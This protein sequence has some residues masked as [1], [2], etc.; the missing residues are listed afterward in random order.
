MP[1]FMNFS[2]D[3]CT[4]WRTLRL[5]SSTRGT[6]IASPHVISRVYWP[7]TQ[8]NLF[9]LATKKIQWSDY[10]KYDS[11]DYRR[12]LSSYSLVAAVGLA[13]CS[14]SD[15]GTVSDN[16]NIINI[17]ECTCTSLCIVFY[18]LKCYFYFLFS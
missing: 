9:L 1:F 15:R 13:F 2:R 6:I 12:Y 8:R 17:S 5:I 14:N 11:W 16:I 7:P 4:I 10:F 18:P 3:S